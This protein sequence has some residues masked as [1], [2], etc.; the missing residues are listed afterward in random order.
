[1][2]EDGNVNSVQTLIDAADASKSKDTKERTLQQ[3]LSS[4]RCIKDSKTKDSLVK[5]IEDKI[6]NL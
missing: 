5:L 3:A 1:M 6:R 4:A 2:W